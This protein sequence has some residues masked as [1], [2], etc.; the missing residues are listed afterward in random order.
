MLSHTLSCSKKDL[1]QS[2]KKALSQP[3]FNVQQALQTIDWLKLQ[4]DNPISKPSTALDELSKILEKRL[5]FDHH[6]RDMICLH[7]VF[8]A[9]V[10]GKQ[11][12]H[13][14]TLV[15]YGD[16]PD[17]YSAMA[18]TVS[19]PAAI[20]ADL[21]LQGNLFFRVLT[22]T[23][24]TNPSLCRQNQGTRSHHTAFIGHL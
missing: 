11:E 17:G 4:S 2:L 21:I 20:G 12:V 13:T 5:K 6:E 7:H 9:E 16:G 10:A 18:K 19:L 22:R 3:Q 14:S 1:K 15:A 23:Y 8:G 24:R